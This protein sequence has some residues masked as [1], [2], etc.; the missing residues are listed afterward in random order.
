MIRL[1]VL[2]VTIVLLWLSTASAQDYRAIFWNLESGE[3]DDTRLVNQMAQKGPVDF[4]GLSEV[5]PNQSALDTFEQALEVREHMEH[6]SARTFA[7]G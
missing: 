4:W 7:Q 2:A 3:S 6:G 1:R 5:P